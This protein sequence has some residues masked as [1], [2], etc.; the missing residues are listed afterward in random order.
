MI[1]AITLNNKTMMTTTKGLTVNE[2][3][4]LQVI[5]KYNLWALKHPE[6]LDNTSFNY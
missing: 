6:D 2:F 1:T 3:M 4:S 5:M